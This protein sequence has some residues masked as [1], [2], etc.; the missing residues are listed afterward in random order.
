MFINEILESRLRD[1]EAMRKAS[2]RMD[3]LRRRCGK[4]E[5]DFNS[6]AV[7]RKIREAR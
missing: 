7:L 5:K 2:H 4:A 6:V 1:R 3:E